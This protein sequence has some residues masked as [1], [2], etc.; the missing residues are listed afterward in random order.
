MY[1]YTARY[2]I[3]E[4]PE[5]TPVLFQRKEDGSYMCIDLHGSPDSV[6]EDWDLKDAV[7]HEVSI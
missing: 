4:W 2:L 7:I 5:H 3:V 1:E 6:L